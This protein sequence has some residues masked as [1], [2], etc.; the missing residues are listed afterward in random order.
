MIEYHSGLK[1]KWSL[2][3]P[4]TIT[5]DSIKLSRYLLK[6]SEAA[7]VSYPDSLL[8]KEKESGKINVYSILADM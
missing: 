7:L 5:G 6:M 3:N 4:N 1:L 2:N 8:H